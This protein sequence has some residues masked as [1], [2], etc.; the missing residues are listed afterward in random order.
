MMILK[1][2]AVPVPV[3]FEF[4]ADNAVRPGRTP[5]FHGCYAPPPLVEFTIP[6]CGLA[7]LVRSTI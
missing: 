6:S 2:R 4:S 1:S 3:E 5:S 7:G